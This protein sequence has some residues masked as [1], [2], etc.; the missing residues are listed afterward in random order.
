MCVMVCR[1]CV[2]S[3]LV[4]CVFLQM[5]RVAQVGADGVRRVDWHDYE[6]MRKDAARTGRSPNIMLRSRCF[7]GH[8]HT[9]M[10]AHTQSSSLLFSSQVFH[11]IFP[12]QSNESVLQKHF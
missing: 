2:N 6:T 7:L 10:H 12:L 3:G 8:T 4:L 11:W 9:D 5:R 1:T